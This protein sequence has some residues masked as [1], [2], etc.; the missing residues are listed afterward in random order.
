MA[1]NVIKKIVLDIDGKEISLTPEQAQKLCTAL[2]DLLKVRQQ[3]SDSAIEELKRL[4]ENNRKEYIPLPYPVVPYKIPYWEYEPYRIT[5]G[6]S[7]DG[8]Y[9]CSATY[10]A[11]DKTVNI[12]I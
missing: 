3:A 4:I 11:S 9:L 8:N 6:S 12:S 10:S 7:S 2:M 1:N 5:W